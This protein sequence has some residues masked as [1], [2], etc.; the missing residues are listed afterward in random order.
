[1]SPSTFDPPVRPDERT[2]RPAPGGCSRRSV[3]LRNRRTHAR[4]ERGFTIIEVMVAATILL[5]GI[6]GTVTMIDAAA[7][8]T[9]AT[10]AREQGVDLQREVIEAARSIP[11]NQLDNPT[12]VSKVQ[13]MPN[14]GNDHAGSGWT[15]QRRGVTYNV[16]L[17]TC[18]VDDPTD[19][20]GTEDPNKFC[21]TNA[22][23]N[24]SCSTLLN[25]STSI[26]G[27]SNV[28]A[29]LAGSLTGQLA[30]GSCGLDLSLNG[31][32]SNLVQADIGLC[33]LGAC[34]PTVGT[35]TQPD[36]YRR[37]VSLVTWK[38]GE[39]LLLGP[40]GHDGRQPGWPGL[41]PVDQC[42]DHGHPFAHHQLLRRSHRA[43]RGHHDV[44][45]DERDLGGGRHRSGHRPPRAGQ[46]LVL[47]LDDRSLRERSRGAGWKLRGL[48]SGD[49]LLW[50]GRS[51]EGAD[52]DPQ[53]PSTLRA[54]ERRGG[55]N[56]SVVEFE[57]AANKERDIAGY[58]VYRS[59][60]LRRRQG[61]RRPD[62]PDQLPGNPSPT[63]LVAALLL[64]RG[65]RP[66]QRGQ[67]EGGGTIRPR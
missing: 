39:Q 11:Y 30:I 9:S 43:V 44:R 60:L 27:N 29:G 45:C 23:P 38:R 7:L 54:D 36:D 42:A 66:R 16:S 41:R 31:H 21:A 14:L 58:R 49:Q 55:R 61:V 63:G 6:L 10:K 1:M 56:G 40:A 33:A 20:Y 35:D 51:H 52:D 59:P 8:T 18:T 46:R 3:T 65:T 67:P 37:I 5:V 26:A 62:H 48:R 25:G 12:I 15:I 57:W 13:A 34:A 64:R 47:Q 4:D 19:G 22:A 53:P 28:I 2:R 50:R 32:V 17:G 24:P